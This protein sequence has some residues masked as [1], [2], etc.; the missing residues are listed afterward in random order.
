MVSNTRASPFHLCA[1]PLIALLARSFSD[2]WVVFPPPRLGQTLSA[3]DRSRS[4]TCHH[5]YHHHR[6][7]SSS[8]STDSRRRRGPASSP[9]TMTSRASTANRAFNSCRSIRTPTAA[10][11]AAAA[12]A[13]VRPPS[14]RRTTVTFHAASGASDGGEDRGQGESAPSLQLGSEGGGRAAGPRCSPP[15]SEVGLRS[16]QDHFASLRNDAGD[17]WSVAATTTAAAAAVDMASSASA[18]CEAEENGI[19]HSSPLQ[20]PQ[21][22]ELSA[23]SKDQE[24]LAGVA[25][26]AAAAAAVASLETTTAPT[27]SLSPREAINSAASARTRLI[28]LRRVSTGRSSSSS[29][30]VD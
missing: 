16:W 24:E 29:V 8:S 17:P 28:R 30:S 2:A 14:S 12:A 23:G 18:W 9:T 10:A 13:V 25:A 19:V 21:L 4:R 6:T 7:S 26:A 5:E 3:A 11:A 20:R 27:A 15:S 1:L 22:G